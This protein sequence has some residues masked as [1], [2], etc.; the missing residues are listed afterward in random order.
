L[1]AKL[2]RRLIKK[3]TVEADLTLRETSPTLPAML[4]GM[5]FS[6]GGAAKIVEILDNFYSDLE[7]AS[8]NLPETFRKDI[9]PSLLADVD[10]RCLLYL[11]ADQFRPTL[12]FRLSPKS[13]AVKRE[14]HLAMDGRAMIAALR[15]EQ[16]RSFL[17]CD[18]RFP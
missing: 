5:A 8:S 4:A 6:A 12:G 10:S 17:D 15:L 16:V 14:F 7:N 18:P 9:D 2:D 1:Y 13:R 3:Y 11:F